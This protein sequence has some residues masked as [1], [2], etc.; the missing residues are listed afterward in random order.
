MS[1]SSPRATEGGRRARQRAQSV[2]E[3]A[4]ALPVLIVLLMSVF[5]IT[6]LISDR[7]AAGYA[8]RQG[9]RMA[10]QLGTGPGMTASQV[11]Q[12][13]CQSVLVSS[14]KLNFAALT[15]VNIYRV[16]QTATDGTWQASYAQDRYTVDS[17][18]TACTATGTQTF[19]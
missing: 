2:V 14:A 5:N 17:S 9:A 6:V 1:A 10:A 18:F 16:P 8:T 15:E 4:L 11:D 3:L 19:T 13:I 7:I 12:Q